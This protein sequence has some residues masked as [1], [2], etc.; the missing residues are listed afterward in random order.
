M[1]VPGLD[2]GFLAT[3]GLTVFKLGF[4]F[5]GGFWAGFCARGGFWA[6]FW[7]CGGFW[8]RFWAPGGGLV[9]RNGV[10]FSPR[11]ERE[12]GFMILHSIA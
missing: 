7:L 4:W 5:S 11:L 1:A 10:V 8:A 9:S 2:S 6:G 3:S 12:S